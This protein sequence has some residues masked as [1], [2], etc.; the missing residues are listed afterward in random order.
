MSGRQS[1]GASRVGV[2]FN[3]SGSPAID[4]VKR[5]LAD[6]IDTVHDLQGLPSSDGETKRTC[7]VAMTLVEDAAMWA[8]KACARAEQAQARVETGEGPETA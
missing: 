8:V 5:H 2:D 1:L 7:S 4:R 3:P 6:V